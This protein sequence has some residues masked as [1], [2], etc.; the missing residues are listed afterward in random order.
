MAPWNNTPSAP[1]PVVTVSQINHVVS[2]DIAADRRLLNVAVCGEISGFTRKSDTGHIYFTLKDSRSRLSVAFFANYA[3]SLPKAVADALKNGIRVICFG[4]ITVYEPN[5]AYQ[6]KC[7][8]LRLDGEGEAALAL[9][10]LRAQLRQEGLFD[11]K[12]PI[13]ASPKKIAV[14]SSSEG[15]GLRDIIDAI[16]QRYPL[17]TLVVVPSLVQG[18]NAPAAIAR[19]MQRAQ[20]TGADTI[21]L[22]RG[23]GPMDDLS[24][25][26]TEIVARAVF[27][28]EIPV[29]S[30]VGHTI[31]HTLVDDVADKIAITPTQAASFAVPDIQEILRSLEFTKG[32]I[33]A[34]MKR[35][36]SF[37]IKLLDSRAEVV[38]ARS[39]Q[40]R[41]KNDAQRLGTLSDG[42]RDKLHFKLDRAEKSLA[43]N[44]EVISALNP[45]G[46][47][48]RGY[49]VTSSGD[50]II[51]KSSELNV[52]DELDI[53]LAE[54]GVKACVTEI[55]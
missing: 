24:T 44:A 41:L 16:G 45:L 9:E 40:S 6:L 37:Y 4:Q 33:S 1:V 30:A 54:G 2:A 20:T 13:P 42:I 27:A 8:G 51:T 15:A 32:K 49:S 28:S 50:R 17:V 21:I 47:L 35:K 53:R 36:T 38:R 43:R 19:A 14:V 12:R 10:Q 3:R 22:G 31:N 23:G 29:I 52:G 34:C 7:T 26:D 25:F 39:P 48:V 55:K 11:R 5:G 18:A 46:V